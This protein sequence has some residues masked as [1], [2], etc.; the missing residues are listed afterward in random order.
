MCIIL[1]LFSVGFEVDTV[2][3]LCVLFF[4]IIQW[5]LRWVVCMLFII[6]MSSEIKAELL[7]L[8]T[9][10]LGLIISLLTR[11]HFKIV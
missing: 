7:L 4:F 6:V 11:C 1:F 2:G 9:Q 8:V 10:Y 5:S 3:L